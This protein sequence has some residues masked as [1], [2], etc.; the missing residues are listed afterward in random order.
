MMMPFFRSHFPLLL[1][2]ALFGVKVHRDVSLIFLSDETVVEWSISLGKY[3]LKKHSL[4]YR[5]RD[6]GMMKILPCR[7]GECCILC[8][9]VR[10]FLPTCNL[11]SASLANMEIGRRVLLLHCVHPMHLVVSFSTPS[12][13]GNFTFCYTNCQER[14]PF[15]G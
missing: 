11:L 13:L 9:L 10:I 1:P 3:V 7:A 6:P 8:G 2:T 4:I 14:W 12:F 15:F 5:D